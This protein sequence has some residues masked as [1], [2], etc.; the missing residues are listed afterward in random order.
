MSIF[1]QLREQISLQELAGRFTEL[2]PSGGKLKGRCPFADHKDEEPSF[3][4]YPDGR[5]HCFGCR[6]HGDVTDLWAGMQGLEPG[7]EAARALARE[8]GIELPDQDPEAAR[9]AQKRRSAEERFLEQAEACHRALKRHRH[10]KDWWEGRGFGEALQKRFLLGTNRDGTEAVIPFWSRG[11][12]QGLIRRKLEGEPKYILPRTEDLACGHRPLF[13]PGPA[14]GDVF[15]VEG[16]VDALALTALGQSAVAVGGTGMSREQRE[17]LLHLPG[18]LYI[19]PDADAEGERAARVWLREL[20][21]KALLCR[22][23]YGEG[24]KDAA[25][26]YAAQREG[27]TEVLE[28]LKANAVDALALELSEARAGRNSLDAYR[29]CK[30]KILPLLVELEDPGERDAALHDV[31]ARLKLSIKPLRRALDGL[32]AERSAS[33]KA[34]AEQGGDDAGVPTPGSKRYERAMELLHD[35]HLLDRAAQDME[36]LGHVGEPVAK[37]LAFVCAVSARSGN[38]I[39]PS[40]HAQSSAGKNFLWDTVLSLLPP[41]MVIRRSGLSAKALFRTQASLKG[42]VLY[43][44]EVSGSEDAEYTIRVM[45]SDGRLEYEATEKMPD[46]SMKNV[47]H[48][49]EGPTVVVQTTT[50]SH[51]HPENETRVFPIYLD[52]SEHQTARIVESILQ[53]A[54]GGGVGGET[55]ESIVSR[56][57]DAIRLL[58]PASVVIPY[59]DR[60]EIPSSPLRI[61]RD[62][63]RLIDVVRVIAWLHQ[64]QRDRNPESHIIATEEDFHE[65]LRLVSESLRRAWQTLTPAEEAALRTIRE[66][67]EGLRTKGFRRRDLDV[68]ELSDR[69]VKLALKSLTDTGYLDCDGRAGPQGYTYTLARDAEKISLGIRLCPLPDSRESSLSKPNTTGQEAFARYCPIP[70]KEQAADVSGQSGK[71]GQNG[72]CPIKDADLQGKRTIGQSGNPETEE[73]IFWN[74]ELACIA[75]ARTQCEECWRRVHKLKHEGM[76]KDWAIAEV[77]QSDD[78]LFS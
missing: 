23:S 8:Y 40:T 62:A 5:F 37:R 69:S 45:Q 21:P 20:Y 70:D 36:Q 35:P 49:T 22:A 31:A 77:M 55:R 68:K 52:E 14:H 4:V 28:G 63:R 29:R 25:D 12:V 78:A 67:P 27:A 47:V 50:R 33:L 60:I 51:L 46:G 76:A 66:L 54:A 2:K 53:E 24:C 34:E 64:H 11:R 9:K 58:E 61:R 1:E 41:E 44:Q 7:I 59:A 13:I 65:A 71:S 38:P 15:L 43:I 26:L 19:L 56:W 73:K 39:Q 32:R 6:R 72:H 16:Y 48:Q 74:G 42:A 57:H 10:V 30:E 17:D 3:Y 18:S 75:H